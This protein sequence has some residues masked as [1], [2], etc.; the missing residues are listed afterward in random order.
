[1]YVGTYRRVIFLNHTLCFVS[2]NSAL[3]VAV[4]IGRLYRYQQAGNGKEAVEKTM[5]S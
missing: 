1:M 5:K 4:D 3:D 2:S